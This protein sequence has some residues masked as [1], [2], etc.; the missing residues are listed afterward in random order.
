MRNK[1]STVLPITAFFLLCAA[2]IISLSSI[3]P[4]AKL[5]F[6]VLK[7]K[8][9]AE[10]A[11]RDLRVIA[12][13]P[14]PMGEFPAHAAVR[15][16]LLDEIRCLGLEAQVQ[17]TFGVRVVHP[18]FVLGGGV[19]NILTKLPGSDPDGAILLIAHYDSTPGG[20]GAG[21]N[22]SGVVTLLEI[23]RNLSADNTLRQDVVFLFADGH[24][25]GIIGSHA[26]AAQH[27]WYADIS[28]VINM[29]TFRSGPPV[30]AKTNQGNGFW[31]Q[32]LANTAKR[33]AYL[34]LPLHLFPSGD[35][36]L[37]PFRGTDL[38]GASF[39]SSAVA[40]ESHTALDR[41]ES[42]D[43]DSVQQAGNHILALVRYLGDK[44][45]LK[46]SVQEAYHQE[47]RT[48]FP[49]LGQLV[50]Y[51][52]SWGLPLAVAAGFSFLGVIIYGFFK[53]ELTWK[54]MGLGFLAMLI[55]LVLSLVITTPLWK[56]IQMLHPEYQYSSFRPHL[57]DDWLYVFGF[58]ALSLVVATI[59]IALVRMRSTTS[60]LA[61]GVL[62]FWLPVTIAVAI[63]VPGTS[64]LVAW[65][66]LISSLALLW[67]LI[68]KSR[69]D[70]RVLPG[71]GF[72]ASAILATFLWIPV[73]N[74]AFLGLGLTMNW[75]LVALAALWIGAMLPFLDWITSGTRWLPPCA[76]MLMS[77]GFLL[78][79]H[80]LVGKHSPPPLVNSIGYW[81][82]V[83]GNQASWIAFIGGER[84]DAR[85]NARFRVAFPQAMDERQH[86]LLVAPIR[87]PYTE[88]FSQAPPFSVLT[89]QAPPLDLEGP[90]L[91][92]LADEW[93]IDH[94][95]VTVRVTTSMLD[96]VYLIIPEGNRLLALT[97][98]DN[99]KVFLSAVED[100]DWMLRFDGMPAEG[101]QISFEFSG[102]SSIQ[103][104]AV[105][106]KT[107]LPSFPGL[108]T[109][110][111]PGTMPSPGEFFQ[112]VPGDFTVI[113]R[114]Y[115]IPQLSRQ[116]E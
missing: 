24:E 114:S 4:P 22:G 99:E 34:S 68:N 100:R 23:L 77:A 93:I 30:L 65:V 17:D 74:S 43:P 71:L 115:I 103:V 116:M 37:I 27:P 16:Y 109:Q 86:D 21:D 80:F 70:S 38:P 14:H 29:D 81:L 31:V 7:T 18:G 35:S 90:G 87:R 66:L 8:F 96:R 82:D 41:P 5:P 13:E 75:V 19:E 25:P 15:D 10:R 111:E 83:D 78:A 40:Q 20:P 61:A 85:T 95:L 57:S 56:G 101:I 73:L 79:G 53:G 52:A 32:A 12:R 110:A 67:V 51:P 33:P 42:V 97:V 88:L 112:G 63:L 48:F 11:M 104:L 98:P 1:I 91:E 59:S 60:E 9:S 55:F 62:S 47:E 3:S 50:H 84:I 6:D 94:R 69:S 64:Y 28:L 105:E 46:M 49:L 106:E 2:V 58:I 92:V 36:D 89:S 113:S 108:S 39:G 107:G 72:L 102:S 54:G 26:F 45:S 76:A 44:P